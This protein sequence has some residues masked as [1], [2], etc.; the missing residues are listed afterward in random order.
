[1]SL[2]DLDWV[3]RNC[4]ARLFGENDAKAAEEP[5]F[6]FMQLYGVQDKD[7]VMDISK[8]EKSDRPCYT[9]PE[10]CLGA[11]ISRALFYKLETK[12]RMTKLGKRTIIYE[13]PAGFLERV[14]GAV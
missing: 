6:V 3:F 1:M 4:R 8:T 13:S 11:R 2:R 14:G 10:W 9:V 7:V 12:P 5:K